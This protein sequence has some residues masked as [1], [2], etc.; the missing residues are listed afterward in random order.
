MP[1]LL[2]GNVQSSSPQQMSTQHPHL[3]DNEKAQTEGLIVPKDGGFP[4]DIDGLRVF[5]TDASVVADLV[6]VGNCASGLENAHIP[7]NE[8]ALG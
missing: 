5:A 1:F 2:R 7:R 3:T 6:S 8:D 4:C